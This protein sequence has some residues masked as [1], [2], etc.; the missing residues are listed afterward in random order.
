MYRYYPSLDQIPGVFRDQFGNPRC[1]RSVT[2]GETE[3]VLQ[4]PIGALKEVVL[5]DLLN[6]LR[7]GSRN[8]VMWECTLPEL[9]SVIEKWL[10][11]NPDAPQ[12]LFA[13]GIRG[14]VNWEAIWNER[15]IKSE[16]FR[17]HR[18]CGQILSEYEDC[19]QCLTGW[20]E[21]GEF[22]LGPRG[23]DTY[24]LVLMGADGGYVA[25]A[26]WFNRNWVFAVPE[27]FA[28]SDY[29]RQLELA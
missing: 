28:R 13:P 4:L 29:N 25:T 14:E 19:P 3:F 23:E 8:S 12:D 7:W 5:S 16:V 6:W 24:N 15:G 21:M 10:K 9:I 18:C 26:V 22:W 17:K 11:D 2:R 20:H 1:G 27:E